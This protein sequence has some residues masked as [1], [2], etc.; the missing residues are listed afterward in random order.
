MF[1]GVKIKNVKPFIRVVINH[2][3]IRVPDNDA[4][5]GRTTSQIDAILKPHLPVKGH[6]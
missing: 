6:G 5:F 3:A 4:T 2:V 1:V